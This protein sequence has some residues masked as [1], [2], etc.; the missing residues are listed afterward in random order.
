MI[1]IRTAVLLATGKTPGN[2]ISTGDT[3]QLGSSV[4]SFLPEEN[5]LELVKEPSQCIS[6]PIVT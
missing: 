5:T 6:K 1:D 3:L 2:P 4:Y